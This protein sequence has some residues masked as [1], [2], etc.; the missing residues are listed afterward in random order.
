MFSISFIF[1]PGTYDDEFRRLDDATQAVADSTEGFLG[2]ETWWSDDRTV[3]NAVYYWDAACFRGPEEPAGAR[4]GGVAAHGRG[5][6]RGER[7]SVG[8]GHAAA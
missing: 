6:V 4:C 7:R 2:A 8:P 1:K 3:C 5:H